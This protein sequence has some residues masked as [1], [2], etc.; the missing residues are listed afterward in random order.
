MLPA[1]DP[2]GA[3]SGEPCVGVPAAHTF[4]IGHSSDTLADGTELDGSG[5]RPA[6]DGCWERVA[7]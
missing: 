5:T 1:L 2:L 4:E 6:E 7:S 3:K